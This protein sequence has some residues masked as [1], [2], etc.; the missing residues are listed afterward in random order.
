MLT[1]QNSENPSQGISV[2]DENGNREEVLHISCNIRPGS[3]LYLNVDVVNAN[4]AAEH[5]DAVQTAM[6][7]FV[8]DV[9]ARAASMGLPVPSVGG[10]ANA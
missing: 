9:F 8:A 5:L 3:G 6:T 4:K 10:V 2:T 7:D 1:I